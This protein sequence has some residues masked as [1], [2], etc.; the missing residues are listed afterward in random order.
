M[1]N[2]SKK[3]IIDFE[4]LFKK[5]IEERNEQRD[6]H[7]K[8]RYGYTLLI[9]LV[10]MNVAV[11]FFYLIF[12]AIPSFTRTYSEEDLII[13]QI[14]INENALAI[15]N[16]DTYQNNDYENRY[17]DQIKSIGAYGNY[18]VIVNRDNDYYSDILIT[19]FYLDEGKLDTILDGSITEWTDGS[20]ILLISG[21]NQSL[22]PTF[23][24]DS[25]QVKGPRTDLT[26]TAFSF[27]NF[28]VYI[29][30]LPLVYMMIK[31]DIW[32]DFT[33]ARTWKVEWLSIILVGYVYLMLGN[34]G[35]NFL[36][37]MFANLFGITSGDSV[38]Q[39]SIRQAISS[40]GAIFMVISAVLLGPIV[41]E[42]VF[43]KAMF[44]LFKKPNVGLVVSSLTFG[45]IHLLGE[46]SIQTA[47]VNGIVYFVMGF[48]FGYIYLK[49]N[50]N[51]FAPLAVH[52]LSNLISIIFIFVGFGG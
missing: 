46:T 23:T 31:K 26:T 12:M 35:S 16:F 52:I 15:M 28:V 39:M 8:R 32:S 29:T 33:I 42:L 38:N 25:I 2:N 43:R 48:V 44:G 20:H 49:N 4:D 27:L 10:M 24:S 21:K 13:N 51:L 6:P 30:M 9:Y 41:E 36:S 50:K 19:E 5:E 37:N 40:N 14:I 17:L 11:A 34:I 7:K 1:D 47:I 22:P 45:A 3:E 18:I